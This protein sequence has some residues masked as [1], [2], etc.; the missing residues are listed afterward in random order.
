[1]RL[2]QRGRVWWMWYRDANGKQVRESTGCHDRKAAEAVVRDRERAQVDP[3][4]EASR[5]ATLGGALAALIERREEEANAG[6]RSKATADFYR[7]KAGHLVRV[8]ETSPD[9]ER[10]PFLLS[11]LRAADVDRYISTRRREGASENTISKELVTLRAALKIALRK[12]QWQGNIVAV[13]PTAFAP[14][15]KPRT[16]F[17]TESELQKL[18]AQLTPDRAARV[19]FIVATSA[20]W[21]ET[22]R[23]RRDHIAKD[24]ANVFIDGTKRASRKRT[25]PI[26]TEQQRSL[27]S[28]RSS[29]PKEQ[30]GCSSDRGARSAAIS[31]RP[32]IARES[33][34][35]RPTI[36]AAP[37]RRG[38][39]KPAHRRI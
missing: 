15:Y 5:N 11:R 17:L 23:A 24:N 36:F 33:R 32:A 27:P 34:N 25:V 39:A 26:V 9:G 12:G 4:Y 10:Q 30:T 28:T 16:R 29:T 31:L 2:Y 22:E 38:S 8:L 14:E 6:R 37:A 35:A 18:L 20:C 13:I 3:D 1:M 21:G 7:V 19:A